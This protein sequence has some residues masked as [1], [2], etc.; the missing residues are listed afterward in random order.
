MRTIKGKIRFILTLAIISLAVIVTLSIYF[1]NE[2]S[3]MTVEMREIQTALTQSEDLKYQ[4]LQARYQERIFMNDPSEERAKNLIT[5]VDSI[6]ENANEYKELQQDHESIS[7]SF[8]KIIE[9]IDTYK[10]ELSTIIDLQREIGF[11]ENSGQYQTVTEAYSNTYNLLRDFDNTEYTQILLSMRMNESKYVESGVD[12][13]LN[14]FNSQMRS[15]STSL[16]E[17]P[18]IPTE[19]LEEINSELTHYKDSIVSI[20]ENIETTEQLSSELN[21]L[22]ANIDTE[23]KNIN[24]LT[25]DQS[26]NM[27][28]Q[29]EQSQ[30]FI[31]TLF[32]VIGIA[33]LFIILI[34]G[35]ILNRKIIQSINRLKQGANHLESGNL[36]HRVEV[37]GKDEMAEL[38]SSF[39]N[40]ADK[41]NHS[42]VKVLEASNVLGDS[43]KNLTT[44]SEQ[45][46]LQTNEVAEAINQVAVG[47][48]EQASQ[49]EDSTRLIDG[50]SQAIEKTKNANQKIIHELK[51]A[52]QDSKSGIEKVKLLEETSNDFIQLANHLT[53]EVIEATEQSKK[54]NQI[55]STI[56]EIADN[57]NLLALNAAIESARAGENGRGFA[58]VADEVRKLAER[59]KA[60][61]A[62][63]YQLINNM[64][65]QM[66]SLS[67]DANQFN[68]YQQE[69]SDSVIE[70]KNAFSNITKHVYDVN[71]KMR[72]VNDS[73]DEMSSANQNLN[74]KIQEISVISE[75]AVATTEEVAASSEH[76]TETIEQLNEAAVHLH[77]LSQ[78]LEAEVGEFTLKDENIQEDDDEVD[79]SKEL[80]NEEDINN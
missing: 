58:V 42:L 32:I 8:E 66:E 45:S 3:K 51:L 2:Q 74:E 49:I 77:A 38:A 65:S 13:N 59:S 50:V 12:S 4:M 43:S 14:S 22:T 44:I 11:S 30:E 71:D 64:T 9:H 19:Q 48:Q 39:N 41:M 40:M 80:E 53:K 68:E 56:Q 7:N 35:I 54:I 20:R 27:I 21:K 55:V 25:T 16:E 33:T 6:R 10:N 15:L 75:E 62:E 31:S 76:Q 69:Q 17:L 26:N 70:T 5:A 34:M 72:D 46:S 23:V 52:E 67:R 79:S 36:S 73:V 29:Q 47:S 37:T 57:T 78:E 28:Q 1:F 61:A 60:E 24:D 18:N 63:I